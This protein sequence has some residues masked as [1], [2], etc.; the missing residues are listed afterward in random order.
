[1]EKRTCKSRPLII[2]GKHK[3]LLHN[4]VVEDSFIHYMLLVQIVS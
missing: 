4:E 3:L 2:V 1:M